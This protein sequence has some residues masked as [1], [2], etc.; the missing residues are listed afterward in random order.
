MIGAFISMITRITNL[1]IGGYQGFTVDKSLVKKLYSWKE[2]K[3]K[4][5]GMR[6]SLNDDID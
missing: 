2:K 4:K 1:T 5:K 6:L 3:D